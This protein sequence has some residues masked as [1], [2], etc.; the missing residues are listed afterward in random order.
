MPDLDLALAPDRDVFPSAAS[1]PPGTLD[2]AQ[3]VFEAAFSRAYD[4][5][6]A[7]ERGE[8]VLTDVQVEA[9]TF[10]DVRAL[11][12]LAA[13]GF[14]RAADPA[15]NAALVDTLQTDIGRQTVLHA[16][17]AGTPTPGTGD[18]L[19][20]LLDHEGASGFGH[21]AVLIGNDSEGWTLHSK[22]G[23]SWPLGVV[24][25]ATWTNDDGQG[26]QGGP[27]FA[28]FDTLDDFFRDAGK[29]GLADRYEA[30]VRIEFEPGDA[31]H[32]GDA[33]RAGAEAIIEEPYRLLTSSCAHTVERALEAAGVEGFAV[34]P[35]RVL[36]DTIIPSRQFADLRRLEFADDVRSE[37]QLAWEQRSAADGR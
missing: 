17:K 25:P 14:G 5:P 36:R 3:T 20:V 19:V 16:L 9:R 34:H 22:D 35:T 11:Q 26:Q 15:M 21:T 37:A 8:R 32:R 10:G 1:T 7:P 27:R 29:D 12:A 4:V 13:E 18:D 28:Q 24:G 30:A 31:L 2:R 6:G 33:A 23:T